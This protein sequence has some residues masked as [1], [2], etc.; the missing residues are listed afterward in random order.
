MGSIAYILCIINTHVVSKM[1]SYKFSVYVSHQLYNTTTNV[2]IN[3]HEDAV[4]P[5]RKR[6]MRFKLISPWIS[7]KKL[8]YSTYLSG[9]CCLF[10]HDN[11]KCNKL[12]VCSVERSVTRRVL[13]FYFRRLCTLLKRRRRTVLVGMR[14]W[15]Q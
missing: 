12:V 9:L 6:I 8:N 10:G 2:Y 13:N 15:T 7:S 5:H 4:T 14:S 11:A 1:W 3:I